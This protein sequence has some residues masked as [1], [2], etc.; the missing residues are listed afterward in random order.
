MSDASGNLRAVVDTNVLVSAA[1]SHRGLPRR[2][3]EAWEH[4]ADETLTEVTDVL[5]RDAIRI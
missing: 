5:Q 1:I 3:L 2:V 4:G